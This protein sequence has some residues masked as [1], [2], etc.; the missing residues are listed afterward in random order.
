[1]CLPADI[2]KKKDFKVYVGYNYSHEHGTESLF[3]HRMDAALLAAHELGARPATDS[4]PGVH[5]VTASGKEY[6]RMLPPF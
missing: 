2:W 1:V 5:V 3:C 6:L 4:P